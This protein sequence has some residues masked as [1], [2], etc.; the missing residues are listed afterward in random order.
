MNST[1]GSLL[2]RGTSFTEAIFQST[3]DILQEF[4]E[5]FV[6]GLGAS[7]PNGADGTLGNLAELFPER[8]I[9]TPVSEAAITG[10]ALGAAISGMRPIVHHGRVEFALFAADQIVTQA[11]N[12]NYMF[13]GEYPAPIV[14][15]VAL[16]RQWGNGPQHTQS[17]IGL[18]G[19]SPGLK[20]VAPS[21]PFMAKG[22]LRAAVEDRNPVVFLES[23]WLYKL[24][25]F[26]PPESYQIDL[27]SS[28]VVWQ[29]GSDLTIVAYS[30]GVLPAVRAGQA[31]EKV[32]I[33]AEIIDLVTLNPIDLE[34]IVRS[35]GRS[36]TLVSI[37]M[38]SDLFSTGNIVVSE[39]SK[40]LN[41]ALRIP[42]LLISAP[43]TPVPT[44]TSLTEHYYPNE[45]SIC[46][47]I[48]IHLG[49]DP[50][51]RQL[52]FEELHLPPEDY[53]SW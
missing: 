42:P 7:Y 35:V 44:A 8:L 51:G 24:R 40:L 52:S 31:L 10:A 16:G 49:Q 45:S 28:R 14:F 20:V 18:F 3:F 41:G 11:S 33:R 13:G 5:S 50:I 38:T 26:V 17:L 23:R 12:W 4:P 48:L 15:R 46:D 39:I 19:S 9:D 27:G 30:D 22:L 21:S 43:R 53:L 34:P 6:I 36:G 2:V 37:D 1:W 25:Q 29:A 32:G 47:R